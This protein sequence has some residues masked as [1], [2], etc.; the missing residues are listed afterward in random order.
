VVEAALKQAPGENRGTRGA[1]II[2]SW[3]ERPSQHWT[4]SK[5]GEQ[6]PRTGARVEEFGKLSVAG[7]HVE[8]CPAPDS[9][10]LITVR[11]FL[12]IVEIA[13]SHRIV[14]RDSVLTIDCHK[15]IR[16]QK[17]QWTQQNGVYDGEQRNAR[18][19]ADRHH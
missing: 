4:D 10:L 12:P 11:G 3:R 9:H 15:A 13:R 6:I 8:S 17:W 7:R 14:G 5:R 16:L 2:V 1:R 18:A 19:N